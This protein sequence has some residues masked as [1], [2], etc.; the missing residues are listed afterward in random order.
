MPSRPI[1]KL[2]GMQD[3]VGETYSLTSQTFNIIKSYLGLNGYESIDTPI[4]ENTE[5]F[6]R[7]SGGELT[8]LIYTFTDPGGHRVSLRPEFTSSLIRHF[9]EEKNRAPLPIRWQY[10][11]PV[12]RYEQNNDGHYRQFTQIGA[13][14]IGANGINAD[15][16]IVSIASLGLD[17]T[18][19]QSH[20]IRIG[21]L[22]V[23]RNLLKSYDISEPAQLFVISN[24]NRL[25]T[26]ITNVPRLMQQANDVG[27]LKENAEFKNQNL[28]ENEQR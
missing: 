3:V 15:A 10:G 26:K 4:L 24:L 9:I 27:L 20:Q 28:K 7:K 13:E 5:L 16:E 2:S 17:K 6:V 11:G 19:L 14:L 12:F 21:H 1:K 18:G 8:S 25:K 23:L 22:G